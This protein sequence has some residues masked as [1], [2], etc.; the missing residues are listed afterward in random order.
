MTEIEKKAMELKQSMENTEKRAQAAEEKADALEKK[1]SEAMEKLKDAEQKQQEQSASIEALDKSAKE[2]K[3]TIEELRKMIR[4]QPKSFRKAMRDALEEKREEI[5]RSLKGMSKFSIEMK[6]ASTD[7]TPQS[8]AQYTGTAMDPVVHAVPVLA[9]TFILAFGSRDLTSGRIAWVEASTSKNVGYV[10]ELAENSN[11]TTITFNEKYRKP[12]KIATY[13]EISSEMENWFEALYNFC[14]DEGQRLILKD[15]DSKIWSGVGDE[16]TKQDEVF[17][18]KTNSTAFSKVGTY[19]KPTAADV[20]LDAIAQIKKNGFAANVAIVSYGTEASLKGLKDADGN[21]IYD[22]VSQTIGQVR[23][24]ASDN[25]TDT[26]MLIADN[27][28]AEVYFGTVYELEFTRQAATDS[29]R[30]D[31]RRYVQTKIPTPKKKG[32]V[33]VSDIETA[34]TAITKA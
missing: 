29:W 17:G 24:M 4:Q 21:Y 14:V 12:A 3:N 13:M 27:S 7:I 26:E 22:K 23:V 30:V 16:S 33:Y 18:L 11:K 9:N 1:Y 5:E 28:C 25:L 2:Q 15:A 34:I 6:I 19:E 31:Y 32:L 8:G 20:I 10:K